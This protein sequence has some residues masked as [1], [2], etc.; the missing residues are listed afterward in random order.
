[1]ATVPFRG[2]PREIALGWVWDQHN[3]GLPLKRQFRPRQCY[4]S[5]IAFLHKA[6]F[7]SELDD[8]YKECDSIQ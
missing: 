8:E 3:I 6:A 5:E 4:V 2:L 1:M 7:R